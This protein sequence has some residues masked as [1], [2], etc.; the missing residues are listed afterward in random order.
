MSTPKNTRI[1]R[2][3]KYKKEEIKLETENSTLFLN[4]RAKTMKMLMVKFLLVI[5]FVSN[6]KISFRS[7]KT[8]IH[9][10]TATK[11]AENQHGCT[12]AHNI[13]NFSSLYN[14]IKPFNQK[15]K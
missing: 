4:A 14:L 6:L 11:L 12:V 5:V 2:R 7:V 9:W 10:I 1:T 8:N 13:T 15:V 3:K